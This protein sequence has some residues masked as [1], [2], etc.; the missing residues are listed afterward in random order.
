MRWTLSRGQE[1]TVRFD[2]H[3]I[4]RWTHKC[5]IGKGHVTVRNKYMRCEKLSA[6]SPANTSGTSTGGNEDDALND[7]NQ[8]CVKNEW[9]GYN[10][11]ITAE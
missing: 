1:A 9:A 11:T 3:T 5:C 6:A 10:V 4:P 2:E 8:S 7:T